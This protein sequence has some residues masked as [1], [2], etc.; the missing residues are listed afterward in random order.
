MARAWIPNGTRNSVPN[1]KMKLGDG[2]QTAR[3]IF[4]GPR[5]DFLR[6]ETGLLMTLRSRR[7][8]QR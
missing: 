8:R 4:L 5:D 1:P 7:L 3:I 6:D 2:N